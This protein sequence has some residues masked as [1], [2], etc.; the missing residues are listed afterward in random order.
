MTRAIAC[1][2][3]KSAEKSA[4]IPLARSGSEGT[5]SQDWV[6]VRRFSGYGPIGDPAKP[7]DGKL[8]PWTIRQHGQLMS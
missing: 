3:E 5:A 2:A 8:S 7:M 4:K 1:L 6:P